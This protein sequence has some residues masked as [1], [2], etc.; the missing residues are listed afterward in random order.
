M[1]EEEIRQVAESKL[2]EVKY[3]DKNDEID[4]DNI[5]EIDNIDDTDK[6]DNIDDTDNIDEI[7]NL[8][9]SKIIKNTPDE[10]DEDVDDRVHV[11]EDVDDRRDDC[12]IIDDDNDIYQHVFKYTCE[13]E[14]II[15]IESVLLNLE[16][17]KRER[18][19]VK[20]ML[21]FLNNNN[22]DRVIPD[23]DLLEV[24]D[25]IAQKYPNFVDKI[26]ALSDYYYDSLE[27]DMDP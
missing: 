27:F 22:D 10:N 24:F 18:L 11:D 12:E 9:I 19:T 4:N 21:S 25:D 15:F 2:E 16:L 23:F 26:Q 6:I 1:S 20:K 8:T 3:T 5:D 7:D 14:M 13:E 17:T